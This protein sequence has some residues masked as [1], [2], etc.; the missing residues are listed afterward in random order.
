MAMEFED[1]NNPELQDFLQREQGQFAEMGED[2]DLDGNGP[3]EPAAPIGGGGFD[4]G[5][6]DMESGTAEPQEDSGPG[7]AYAAIA[8]VDAIQQEPEC[9]RKWR[10]EQA[11]MLAEKDAQSEAEHDEWL[12]QAKQDLE[13]WYTKRSEHLDKVRD[14]NRAAEEAFIEERDDTAP[15]H[16]WERISQLCDFAPKAN[17][18]TKDVSRLRSIL[19]HLKQEP[20]VR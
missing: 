1:D 19:L 13:E 15:G 12:A 8:H 7:D 2:L 18:C 5:L 9:I 17:K 3:A 6:L 11:T 14:G 16:E 20:L 10:E 4:G